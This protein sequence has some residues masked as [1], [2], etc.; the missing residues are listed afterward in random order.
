MVERMHFEELLCFEP[1]FF[2]LEEDDV[3]LLQEAL[4]KTYENLD[5]LRTLHESVKA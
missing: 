5:E 4:I 1:C 2:N 3:K